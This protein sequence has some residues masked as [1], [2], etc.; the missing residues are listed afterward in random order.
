MAVLQRDPVRTRRALLDAAARRVAQRGA[1][2]SLDAVAQE[3]G[4]SKGG[5]LHHFRSREALLA[6][7]VEEWLA[8]FDAAVERH[9][10]PADARPGRLTRAYVRANVDIDV[11]DPDARLWR[12]SSVLTALMSMPG[13]LRLADESDRR[14]HAALAADGLHPDRVALI[15]S[16]LDGI[17]YT[18]LLRGADARAAGSLYDVLLDLT[19]ST[20]PL[21]RR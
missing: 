4:V 14:W 15:T 19:E 8:R 1:T 10:D 13:V 17:V 9:A 12:D 11:I 3:A 2:I 5:L 6:G 21:I 16:A 18:Q 7:L 20:G